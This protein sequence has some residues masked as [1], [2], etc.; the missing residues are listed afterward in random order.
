MQYLVVEIGKE[1]TNLLYFFIDVF[2]LSLIAFIIIIGVL[3]LCFSTKKDKIDGLLLIMLGT[4]G[5]VIFYYFYWH[6]FN[7]W[8]RIFVMEALFS[9]LGAL[10]GVI[11][12]VG[13]FI[14]VLIRTS[15]PSTSKG[16]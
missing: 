1:K 2:L 3:L 15:R 12:A 16:G 5:S 9:N 4:M 8:K 7:V 10:L 14:A 6:Y 11:A 13:I